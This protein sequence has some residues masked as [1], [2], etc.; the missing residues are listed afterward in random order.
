[1]KKRLLAIPVL[2]LPLLWTVSCTEKSAQKQEVSEQGE[3]EVGEE[4]ID[5]LQRM[6]V[7]DYSDTLMRDGHLYA[8]TVHREAVDSLPPVVDEDGVS[9]AANRYTLA[10]QC[11]G[12]PYFNRNFTKSAFSSYLSVESREKGLL[13]GMMCDKSL[14]GLSFAISVTLPQ[15]DM[16]EPLLL[17]VYPGGA[18]GIERDT[19]SEND[20]ED[21]P[22]DNN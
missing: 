19:R 15:S 7:Y 17:H 16:V 10:I 12:K 11:D 22:K 21:E 4:R 1:M 18:I 8:Y 5:G 20:F 6:R 13:D 2:V 3:F 9:Y 14:P